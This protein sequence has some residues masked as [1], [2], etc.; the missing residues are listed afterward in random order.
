[1]KNIFFQILRE[2]DK[3]RFIKPLWDEYSEDNEDEIKKLG[4]TYD[5][6]LKFANSDDPIIKEHFKKNSVDWQ[7]KNKD[8]IKWYSIYNAYRDRLQKNKEKEKSKASYK[9]DTFTNMVLLSDL[10]ILEQGEPAENVDFVHLTSL[11]NDTFEFYVPMTHEACVFCDSAKAGGQGAK[12]CIGYEQSSLYWDEYTKKGNLFILAFNKKEFEKHST[13]PTNKLKFMIQISPNAEET[14]AWEQDDN[15]ESTIRISHFEKIF[16]HS[17]IEFAEVFVNSILSDDNLYSVKSRGDFIN[18]DY[19]FELPWQDHEMV[20]EV[21]YIT[22][23]YDGMYDKEAVYNKFYDRI[24]IDCEGLKVEPE[25]MGDIFNSSSFDIPTLCTWLGEAGCENPLIIIR[26]GIFD[27]L[28]WEP[29][30]TQ[31]QGWVEME[32]CKINRLIF[33]D[34]SNADNNLELRVS[35][36]NELHWPEPENHIDNCNTSTFQAFNTDIDEEIYADGE[37]YD[38]DEDEN[39][40]DYYEDD[41]DD[42]NEILDENLKTFFQNLTRM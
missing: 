35:H 13:T 21:F 32:N 27:E 33:T 23:F 37:E 38:D 9:A 4:I 24:I 41:Y 29:E 14:Q 30:A 18:D 28:V 2:A 20:D 15:S 26:N 31:N 22:E 19:E 7:S 12:W 17:A 34:Y 8:Y 10:T 6:I 42:E 5:K 11:D 3:S 40:D 16:G 36:V 39:Y 1:M 25:K